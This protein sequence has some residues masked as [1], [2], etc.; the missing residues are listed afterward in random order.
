MARYSLI[1]SAYASESP[2]ADAETLVNF[3]LE[4]IE[5][6][7]GKSAAAL[8]PRPSLTAFTILP[9]SPLRG[10]V[11][12]NGRMFAVAGASLY[13]VFADAT[14]SRIAGVAND[15]QPVSF[16]ASTSQVLLVSGG[17]VYCLTLYGTAL[18][19]LPHLSRTLTYAI[20]SVA[21]SGIVPQSQPIAIQSVSES[22]STVTAVLNDFLP[23][24]LLVAKGDPIRIS[25]VTE[26]GYDGTVPIGSID[27]GQ[28]AAIDTIAQISESGTTVSL[29]VVD[30]EVIRPQWDAIGI[31]DQITVSGV[32]PADYNGTQTVTGKTIT[33]R[34]AP[35]SGFALTLTYEIGPTGL[36]DGGSSGRPA[37]V[38]YGATVYP[39]VTY[40]NTNLGLA[41][42]SGGNMEFFTVLV[43]TASDLQFSA[44]EDVTIAAAD[45]AAYDGVWK[46]AAITG[47][48][49]P[50]NSTAVLHAKQSLIDEA[51][52]QNGT[53]SSAIG[54]PVLGAYS[55][56]FFL[57]L[58]DSFQKWRISGLLDGLT[59]DDAD[60][61][62]VSEIPDDLVSLLVDHREAWMFGR[63]KTVV[64]YN[65]GNPDFPF[66]PVNGGFIEQGC[67]AARSPIRMDNSIFWLGRDERG[68]L[69]AWRAQGYLPARVSDHAVEREWQSY[70]VTSDA[71]SMTYQWNGHSFWQIYFPTANRTWVYDAATGRWR[72]DGFWSGTDWDAHRAFCHVFAFGKHLVGDPLSGGI[73]QLTEPVT[74]WLDFGNPVMGERQAPPVA[75]EAEWTYHSRIVL[76][77]EMAQAKAAAAPVITLGGYAYNPNP[78]G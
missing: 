24:A 9:D 12:I 59:W 45:D 4:A 74:D 15:G 20:S 33:P 10:E 42:S 69:M 28:Q 47:G 3:Y 64:Y 2:V 16:A 22:G 73:Y 76:D 25:G 54:A 46:V 5:S 52:S 60:V 41:D 67:D 35:H 14:Y 18:A 7:L 55:D 31:G 53:I 37:T 62:Q 61:A 71:V 56:G 78:L 58:L 30:P 36:S 1:G 32:V 39:T 34:T 66:E 27:F 51:A 65:S 13:E 38:Q 75:T 8:Y 63:T 19:A 26:S 49:G 44:G 21:A 23:S 11:E 57:L 70:L 29:I 17:N 77:V 43:H 50:P 72:R 68:A 6:G 40:E 48:G